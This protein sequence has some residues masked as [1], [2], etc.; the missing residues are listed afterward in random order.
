MNA[1]AALLLTLISTIILFAPRRWA[2]MGMLAGVLYLPQQASAVIFNF[3]LFPQRFIEL[4]GFIRIVTRREFTLSSLN[5][6]DRTLLILYAYATTV[7]LF[8]S[9]QD[10][11]TEIGAAV[12]AFLCY[13]TF[14]GLV[15]STEDLVWSLRVLVLMLVPYAALVCIESYTSHNLFEILGGSTN[16]AFREGR[17]RCLGAFRHPSLLGTMA[18]SFMPLYM[19]L[20]FIKDKMVAFIGVICCLA[21]VWAANSGAPW[22]LVMTGVIGWALW[23]VRTKM[24]LVRRAMT[25][26]LIG[27]ALTMKAPIWYLIQRISDLTG[28]D[29]WH[30]AHLLDMAFRD[31]H[32]WW[33]FGM[34][35]RETASWFPYTLATG[36][37]D[38]T[39]YFLS[40]GI[41]SGFAAMLL[42]IL[43]L[44]RACSSLGKK[45]AVLRERTEAK[46]RDDEF[47]YWALGVVVSVHIFNWLGI[48]YFDQTYVLWFMHLAV[49]STL[50]EDVQLRESS[51]HLRQSEPRFARP[52]PLLR[53]TMLARPEKFIRRTAKRAYTFGSA[54]KLINAT[55]NQ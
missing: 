45:M 24:Y 22:S 29:G 40:F 48:T 16:A 50:T 2:L 42:F 36:A 34:A 31:L 53:P 47:I 41:D 30:R 39:N 27:L 15:R 28:G 8:R 12:D 26:T 37:S 13:F 55:I 20:W 3:N 51:R 43:L 49:I 10:Q 1:P 6:I 9:N 33:M 32:K 4:A 14:R 11:V 52:V 35:P 7:F 21:I 18:G 5:K 46:A 25:V 23:G 38:M 54:G 19:A 44:T 17:I